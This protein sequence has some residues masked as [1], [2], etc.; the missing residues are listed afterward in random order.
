MR[1][2]NHE[3]SNVEEVR[4][5]A[6]LASEEQVEEEIEDEDVEAAALPNESVPEK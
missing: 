2:P 1:K 6:S 3:P 4:K 5:D